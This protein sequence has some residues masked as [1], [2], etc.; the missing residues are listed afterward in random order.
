M[1]NIAV[2]MLVSSHQL[3]IEYVSIPTAIT[4]RIYLPNA[5]VASG[6]NYMQSVII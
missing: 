4:V 5:Y 1:N 2:D 3:S 6:A